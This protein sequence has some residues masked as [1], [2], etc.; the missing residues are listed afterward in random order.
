[1]ELEPSTLDEP[2]SQVPEHPGRA[3]IS[4]LTVDHYNHKSHNSVARQTALLSSSSGKLEQQHINQQHINQQQ[5]QFQPSYPPPPPRSSGSG[6]AASGG[7][8][9]TGDQNRGNDCARV[10][11][12]IV[13]QLDPSSN[14][15]SSSSQITT[16]AHCQRLLTIL[17]CPC[18]EQPV[19]ALLV[20]SACIALMDAIVLQQQQQPLPDETSLQPSSWPLTPSSPSQPRHQHSR[21]YD[22]DQGEFEGLSKIAKVVLRFT[23][24]YAQYAEGG[25]EGATRALLE[26]VMTLLRSKLQFVTEEATGRLVL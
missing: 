25:G 2:P 3:S 12:S 4:D 7:R 8:T 18:S 6:S 23:Q 10:A 14:Y 19:V 17:V 22:S 21:S 13:E 15:S 16:T 11:A 5:Q 20:A 26:P 1:M 24:R 9:P